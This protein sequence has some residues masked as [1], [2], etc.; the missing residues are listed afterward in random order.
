MKHIHQILGC[1]PHIWKFW[2]V[3][4]SFKQQ[5]SFAPRLRGLG[6][7]TRPWPS[8][9]RPKA[10]TEPM[11]SSL[12]ETFVA[13][14]WGW[15]AQGGHD[16]QL[17]FTCTRGPPYQRRETKFTSLGVGASSLRASQLTF[18]ISS[19]CFFSPKYRP[20]AY[21]PTVAPIIPTTNSRP[22]KSNK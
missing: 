15:T 8:K 22:S 16:G 2:H 5:I 13:S 3:N 11:K 1:S 9:S 4:R 14:G 18:G 7:Q 19:S 12:G 17:T 21:Y 6:P 20:S 10:A